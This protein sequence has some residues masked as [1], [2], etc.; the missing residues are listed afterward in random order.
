VGKKRRQVWVWLAIN[1]DTREIVG[2]ALGRRTKATARTLWRSI[3]AVYRQC[4][5]GYT[6]FWD[7]YAAVLPAKR[8][9][10]VGKESW[11]DQPYRAL[12]HHLTPAL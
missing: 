6:D 5:V 8:H 11:S 10:T 4:A 3:P 9:R 12:Q 1:R 2:V 7:A